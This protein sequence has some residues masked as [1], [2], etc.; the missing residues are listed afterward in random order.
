[1]KPAAIADTGGWRA[2]TPPTAWT[3]VAWIG[4]AM[5][6]MGLLYWDGILA[7]LDAW[8]RPEY[9]F[10]PLVPLVSAYMLLHELRTKPPVADGGSRVPG[11]VIV[12]FGVLLGILGNLT[13]IPYLIAY[14]LII[15][16]GGIAL[17]V[18]GAR[19][20]LS[21]WPG[22]VHLLFMLPLPNFIYWQLSAFL[23]LI[24]SRLGVELVRTLGIPVFLEG[25]IIDLG[26]YQLQVAEACSGLRYL[27]PL[28]SFGYLFA[29]LYKGPLWQKFTLFI[30]TIPITV[31]MN[32][33]RIGMIGIL[34][35]YYGIEQAEGFLHAFEGWFIFIACV[36]LLYFA[37]LI[38]QR[39]RRKP[40]LALNILELDYDGLLKPF[41]WARNIPAS[42]AIVGAALI[43]VATGV[44]WHLAPA[45]AAPVVER[46]TFG[47]FPMALGDWSGRRGE[48]EDW[49]IAVLAA[50]EYLL[51]DFASAQKQPNVNLFISYYKSTS[52]GTGIHSPQICIPGG[53]WEVS[54]WR[55]AEIS[56]GENVKPFTVNR[57]IIQKGRE[58]QLVYYWFEQRGRRLAS[59]YATKFYTVWDSATTGRADGALVR[60]ITNLPPGEPEADAERRLASFLPAM[61]NVLPSYIP[62]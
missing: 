58:R 9:S 12:L 22:W 51:A 55:V 42:R 49:T 36:V 14:G 60:I 4:V 50:D 17:I 27:F 2:L 31:A 62:N 40:E 29:V 61:I 1:M 10:G 34:V 33:F 53:G 21:Y 19:Q 39:F 23:Q 32:S 25:N 13:Q 56:P 5:A 26:I 35:N 52:D 45:R 15:V 7:L 6:G 8:T 47:S 43:L 24:S 59:E 11:L 30:L 38:L 44:W 28:M 57:A 20:G 18:A 54:G 46:Q 37:G 16:V 48:L 3:G 41:A